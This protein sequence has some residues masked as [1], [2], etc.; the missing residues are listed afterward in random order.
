M[1]D[2]LYHSF[3]LS[4]YHSPKNYGL[5]EDFDAEAKGENRMCGDSI[6][7][8]LKFEGERIGTVS[9]AHE[10]CVISRAA[11]SLLSERIQGK[12]KGEIQDLAAADVLSLLKA[13]ISPSRISCA[14][15]G[16]ETAKK[17]L[18]GQD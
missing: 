7:M 12:T 13:P 6:T 2:T 16:W 17:A 4:H 5:R 14:L 15:L 8:R 9:F 18:A 10:G 3:L 1:Q 11:A